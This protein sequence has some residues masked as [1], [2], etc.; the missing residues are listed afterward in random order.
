MIITTIDIKYPP[1]VLDINV[2]LRHATLARV[3]D[4]ASMI[5]PYDRGEPQTAYPLA[6]SWSRS[7]PLS[8][9]D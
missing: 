7:E 3:G 2:L 1:F 5:D 4:M 9:R 8:I 6:Y